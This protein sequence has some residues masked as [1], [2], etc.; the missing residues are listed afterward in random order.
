MKVNFNDIGVDAGMIIIC[1]KDHFKNYNYVENL[2]ISK[3]ILLEKGD[4]VVNYIIPESWN[5]EISGVKT[6]KVTSGEVIISDPCYC[7]GKSNNKFPFDCWD[8]WLD[9]YNYGDTIPDGCI[10]IDSMGG[11]GRYELE[12]NFEFIKGE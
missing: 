10:L 8:K 3:K 5:G 1:D 11:D 6:L 9:D 7:V 2:K 12:L 4:Y